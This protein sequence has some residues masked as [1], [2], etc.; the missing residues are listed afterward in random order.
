MSCFI[1]DALAFEFHCHHDM[2]VV[3]ANV[4]PRK[5]FCFASVHAAGTFLA[6]KDAFNFVS[7]RG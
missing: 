5:V 1:R 7:M 3:I 4:S 6:H 2:V